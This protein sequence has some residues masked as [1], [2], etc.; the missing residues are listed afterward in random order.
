[1]DRE[2][3]HALEILGRQSRHQVH[4]VVTQR[5]IREHCCRLTLLL[6]AH[7]FFLSDSPDLLSYL[8][9][10]FHLLFLLLQDIRFHL[11]LLTLKLWWHLICL[12]RLL[13][14]RSHLVTR[15][16]RRL[17][18]VRAILFPPDAQQLF[19][20]LL[21]QLKHGGLADRAISTFS[22]WRQNNLL[23]HF[24]NVVSITVLAARRA[25]RNR[26]QSV[27]WQVAVWRAGL[28]RCVWVVAVDIAG[29]HSTL[30]F[31]LVSCSSLGNLGLNWQVEDWEHTGDNGCFPRQLL[32]IVDRLT[33]TGSDSALVL[34]PRKNLAQLAQVARTVDG[35][36]EHVLDLRLVFVSQI[37]TERRVA[38][39]V[40][41]IQ[42]ARMLQ[43]LLA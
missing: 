7:Q 34:A 42:N 22:N 1:M 3:F 30:A 37:L 15:V 2:V 11:R 38:P 25:L 36:E 23:G 39:T 18:L 13:R 27:R 33:E 29:F 40:Q 43:Y 26:L 16:Q 14:A 32:L 8:Q 5:V 35:L 24:N 21:L 9:L 20:P 19:L 4:R 6:E 28:A 12:L 17:T 41:E 10:T 31:A